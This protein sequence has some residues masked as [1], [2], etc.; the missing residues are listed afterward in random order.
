[1]KKR[2]ASHKKHSPWLLT[3]IA[4]AGAVLGYSLV[5]VNKGAAAFEGTAY[6]HNHAAQPST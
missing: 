2:A 4:I 3:T 5:V 6:C 1:M